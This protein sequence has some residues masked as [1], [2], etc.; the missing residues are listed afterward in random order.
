MLT[1]KTKEELAA[2]KEE[3]E[4]LNDK[5]CELTENELAQVSG[6]RGIIPLSKAVEVTDCNCGRSQVYDGKCVKPG[7][8]I[9]SVCKDC[10]YR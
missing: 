10:K 4:A 8:R 2:L 3:A 5:L 1:M 6:G 9:I 7:A